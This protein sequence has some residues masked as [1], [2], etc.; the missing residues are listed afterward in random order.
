MEI[1]RYL[2]SISKKVFLSLF[3]VAIIALSQVWVD[4]AKPKDSTQVDKGKQAVEG[5]GE[6]GTGENI[7]GTR[8][9]DFNAQKP[10]GIPAFE[11]SVDTREHPR[12]VC[13]AQDARLFGT[14][15]GEG[16]YEAMM[17]LAQD[18]WAKWERGEA[19]EYPAAPGIIAA[20]T[21]STI[22]RKY[23][24]VAVNEIDGAL[25][26]REGFTDASSLEKILWAAMGWDVLG[27]MMSKS[28]K[29]NIGNDA[30]MAL[31]EDILPFIKGKL[32]EDG[33]GILPDDL[34]LQRGD[35]VRAYCA[36][37]IWELALAEDAARMKKLL[38]AAY[39]VLIAL[40]EGLASQADKIPHE[41]INGPVDDGL[42]LACLAWEHAAGKGLIDKGLLR[43]TLDSALEYTRSGYAS[44][45]IKQFDMPE[46]RAALMHLVKWR[47]EL[48]DA[49]RG[50]VDG[51]VAQ[52][53][54][55][56]GALM[57]LF[58]KPVKETD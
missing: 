3:L 52:V 33:R 41:I 17:Q 26:P 34:L 9:T 19:G 2:R 39:P 31:D 29:Q 14:A 38:V 58:L 6:S 37:F 12:L 54:Y 55:S 8:F 4:C 11:V 56:P 48:T 53:G 51:W 47:G 1:K 18:L 5:G 25:A 57:H 27:T 21:F 50:E 10:V 42:Y 15:R 16:P 43:R 36:A 35:F 28:D 40:Q 23:L 30:R 44:N 22:N 46:G 45:N 13:D 7:A 49:E 32:P 24:A 20:S